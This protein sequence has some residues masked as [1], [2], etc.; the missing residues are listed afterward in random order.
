M[1]KN[2][3]K[4]P[5]PT[6]PAANTREQTARAALDHV[7]TVVLDK[8]LVDDPEYFNWINYNKIKCMPDLLS[9]DIAN[10][11]TTTYK[12]DG[13]MELP[14]LIMSCHVHNL[15]VFHHLFCIN[16][17]KQSMDNEDWMAMTAEDYLHF[18]TFNHPKIQSSDFTLTTFAKQN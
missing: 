9:I 3:A 2:T 10:M 18:V 7:L 5:D 12:N 15:Q 6:V 17:N 4:P 13:T 14:P 11:E 8:D 1:M 16:N